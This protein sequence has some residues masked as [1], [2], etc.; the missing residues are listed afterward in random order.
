MSIKNI[1]VGMIGQ[2]GIFPELIFIETSD[3]FATVITP[4]YLTSSQLFGYSFSN[5]QMAFVTANDQNALV[6]VHVEDGEVSLIYPVG[7]VNS[8]FGRAGIVVAQTGDYNTSQVTELTNL[9]FTEPRVRSTPL[10]GLSLTNS[11]ITATDSVLA[12][13]GKTQGQINAIAGSEVTSVFGRSGVVV[14]NTG[15]YTAAQVTNAADKASVSAQIF[16]GQLQSPSVLFGTSPNEL[17]NLRADGTLVYGINAD[18]VTPLTKVNIR[19]G[20]F[21]VVTAADQPQIIFTNEDGITNGNVGIFSC[22]GSNDGPIFQGFNYLT[23]TAN[24]TYVG[25]VGGNVGLGKTGDGGLAADFPIHIHGLTCIGTFDGTDTQL[26]LKDEN[27]P[28][29]LIFMGYSQT[30]NGGQFQT[31]AN[32]GFPGD[33]YLSPIGGNV[34]IGTGLSLGLDALLQVNGSVFICSGNRD[35]RLE[36]SFDGSSIMGSIQAND[37]GSGLAE[38]HLNPQGNSVSINLAIGTGAQ[39]PFHVEGDM[40]LSNITLPTTPTGG[41]KLYSKLVT[42]DSNLFYLDSAGTEHQLTN[43]AVGLVT[44]V[45]GRTG[46]VVATTGDYTQ[47]QITNLTTSSSPSFFNLTLTGSAGASTITG[48]TTSLAIIGSTVVNITTGSQI[49]LTANSGSGQINLH[50]ITTAFNEVFI[51]DSPLFISSSGNPLFK[52]QWDDTHSKM[53]MDSLDGVGGPSPLLINPTGGNTG[54]GFATSVTIQSILSSSAEIFLGSIT[55]PSTPTGGGKFYAKSDGDAYFL[56]TAGIERNIFG[57]SGDLNIVPVSTATYTINGTE[58][59]LAVNANGTAIAITIDT[60]LLTKEL[61]IYKTNAVIGSLDI[62]ITPSGGQTINGSSSSI[63]IA[64]TDARYGYIRLVPSDSSTNSFLA[65]VSVSV[66]LSI[67]SDSRPSGLMYKWG[68]TNVALPI[69]PTGSAQYT[70]T[71]SGTFNTLFQVFL[72]AAESTTN[73]PLC[74]KIISQS[75]SGCIVEIFNASGTLTTG[76]LVLSAFAVGI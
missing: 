11:A 12:A 56:N 8:V 49:N 1:S 4:G 70:V 42:G 69:P 74:Y 53:V 24:N 39:S 60:S 73:L 22:S 55:T 43:A 15:D 64:N 54:F 72:S 48:G 37:N 20:D 65:D 62:T 41:G 58:D 28:H 34:G 59:V 33:T 5:E 14:A 16:S 3:D 35:Q 26:I 9:Y 7:E 30:L 40:F 21:S 47:N 44:S 68:F 50:G 2:G 18:T 36:L 6:S 29:S 25:G 46:A 45:F 23:N 67:G 31:M 13:F 66:P 17:L 51:D 19:D 57:A 38:L 63:T 32:L 75:V 27:N 10:T 52:L 61:R 71:W 76:A